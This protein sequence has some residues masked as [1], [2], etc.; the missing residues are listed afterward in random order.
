MSTTTRR[1]ATTSAELFAKLEARDANGDYILLDPDIRRAV[2][3]QASALAKKEKTQAAKLARKLV[4]R[5][6]MPLSYRVTEAIKARGVKNEDELKNHLRTCELTVGT[7]FFYESYRSVYDELENGRSHHRTVPTI[8]WRTITAVAP[9]SD[10][11]AVTAPDYKGRYSW[12]EVQWD[13]DERGPRW[14]HRTMHFD[15]E[16]AKLGAIEDATENVAD[17][18]KAVVTAEADLELVR[19]LSIDDLRKA[20][21]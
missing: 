7:T 9:T 17:K 21:A 10:R 3:A 2:N 8:E 5:E 14:G 12:E 16:S 18:K 1:T 4:V 15:F 19:A 6:Q 11:I 13:Y 20:D